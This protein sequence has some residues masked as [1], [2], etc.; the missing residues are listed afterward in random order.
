MKEEKRRER[1]H[2]KT[3]KLNGIIHNCVE[4]KP[5][6]SKLIALVT[7]HTIPIIENFCVQSNLCTMATLGTKKTGCCS[8]V[9][10]IQRLALKNYYQYWKAG[11][12]AGHCRQ[13]AI[14]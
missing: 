13:V 10:V 14:V 6:N 5:L 11:G 8:K 12:H 1:I 2:I 9:V 3:N 4:I 7:A